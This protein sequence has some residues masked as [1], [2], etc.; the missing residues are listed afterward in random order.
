MSF[1]SIIRPVF[2]VTACG[3]ERCRLSHDRHLGKSTGMSH[4][5]C[6]LNGVHIRPLAIISKGFIAKT[7]YGFSISASLNSFAVVETG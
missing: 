3:A 2:W 4:D 5:T 6:K 7:S 1:R